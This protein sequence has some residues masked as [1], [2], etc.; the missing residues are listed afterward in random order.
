MAPKVCKD[1]S[2]I[3]K[4]RS[5][6]LLTDKVKIIQ[7]VE[8]GM[9][10]KSIMQKYNIKSRSTVSGIKRAKEKIMSKV[11]EVQGN[12]CKQI[13]AFNTTKKVFIYQLLYS[14]SETFQECSTS[15]GGRGAIHLV[16]TTTAK[17]CPYKSRNATSTGSKV[18]FF[19]D[20]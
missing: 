2:G 10:I 3:K 19:N 8:K 14:K 1:F 4:K 9:S 20:W 13:H 17:I 15:S 6:V 7:D 5:V 11:A 12:M 18:L 16:P